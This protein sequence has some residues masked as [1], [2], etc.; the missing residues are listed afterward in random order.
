MANW[1]AVWR[2]A[3]GSLESVGTVI[4]SP[5]PAGLSQTAIG[6]SAPTG[7][8][9]NVTRVFDA[10]AV[11]KSVLPLKDF[12]QRFTQTEREV[13]WDMQASGTAVQ[14]KRLGAFKDYL[15]AAGS[16]DLNDAYIIALVNLMESSAVIGA[17]RAAVILA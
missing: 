3:D 5:L 7:V 11:L 10:A 13:L 17:G 9:N 4:A 15:Q 8:W 2:T 6:T 14:K 12:W 1:F 16:V